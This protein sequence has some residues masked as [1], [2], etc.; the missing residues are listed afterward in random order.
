MIEPQLAQSH[1]ESQEDH[2]CTDESAAEG[3]WILDPEGQT[4]FVT[5]TLADLLG[6]S[7]TELLGTDLCKIV[8]AAAQ[9]SHLKALKCEYAQGYFFARP[10]EP[11]AVESLIATQV[12]S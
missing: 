5:Q 3:I 8:A 10:L 12:K 11:T 7:V 2:P 9:L 1:W 4:C 6:Y